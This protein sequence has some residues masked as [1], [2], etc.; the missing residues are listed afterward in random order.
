MAPKLPLQSTRLVI[1]PQTPMRTTV[2]LFVALCATSLFGGEALIAP[3]PRTSSTVKSVTLAGGVTKLQLSTKA[4]RALDPSLLRKDV[5]A[6]WNSGQFDDIRVRTTEEADGTAVVFDVIPKAPLALHD[7]RIE[8][9]SFGLQPSLPPGTPIDPFRAQQVARQIRR[10][11]VE[12]GYVDANAEPE[13][14]PTGKGKADLFIH[15][16]AGDQVRVTDVEIAGDTVF[17]QKDV[18]RALQALRTKRILPGIPGIWHGFRVRPVYSEEAVQSDLARLQ[19]FYLA[20]GYFDARIAVENSDVKGDQASVRLFVT[21]G[22]KYQVKSWT[23]SGKGVETTS[24]EL[25]GDSFQP[26]ALCSCLIRARREAETRGIV[27]FNARLNFH[28][29]GTTGDANPL[30]ELSAEVEEG[31]PYT[32]GRIDVQGTKH[33]SEANIRRNLLINEDDVLDQTLLRRSIA[34]LNQTQM[35]EQ[36]D[37]SQVV[38]NT[39]ESTGV[40]NIVIPLRER[41][42][43]MWNFSGPV[44]P[45]SF[46]GPLQFMIASRLPP[47]GRG[48]FELSTY[49][50][51]FSMIGYLH[52]ISSLLPL[53]LSKQ[54]ILP[55]FSLFRPYTPGEGWKSGF[56]IAPQLGWKATAYTY[57]T[58]QL[59]SRL[60]PIILGNSRFTSPLAVTFE[61]PNG[62]GVL[63]CEP[64]KPRFHA[65]RAGTAVALQFL[66]SAPGM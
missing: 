13:I 37:E 19:S 41:K 16:T 44:G 63:L 30:V 38:L 14:V 60:V 33:Y 46:A 6:L 61:R 2:L 31:R 65:L 32:V 4:G 10:H 20:H 58:T 55:V 7:F 22:P 24:E 15:V 26:Q 18:T 21:A 45:I 50:L 53:G 48:I 54:G 27:D 57:A 23:M 17:S 62:D 34:R 3:M 47:W 11:L 43:G 64:P 8:P 42:R 56:L 5:Q 51:S 29:V 12:R 35:F 1:V 52:P 66:A 39:D 28:R 36:L 49:Y 9:N 59:S 25:Q 40:A